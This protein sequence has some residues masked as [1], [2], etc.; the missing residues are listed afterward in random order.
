MSK[1]HDTLA[2]Y[3]DSMNFGHLSEGNE[4]FL[5]E[6]AVRD[7][8]QQIIREI[9]QQKAGEIYAEADRKRKE[10]LKLEQQQEQ[11]RK[12]R[13][14][15]T[16]FW[17]VIVLGILIGLV[18]NQLTELFSFLK[19]AVKM[20]LPVLISTIFLTGGLSFVIYHIYQSVYLGKAA[21]L[22]EEFLQKGSERE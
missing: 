8:E 2:K 16:A 21:E 11:A 5:K 19:D 12:I 15:Q 6:A 14:A 9:V 13:D 7:L 4:R 17:T 18:G 20:E 22:I 10:A 1:L 3:V